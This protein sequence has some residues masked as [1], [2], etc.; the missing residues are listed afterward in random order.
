MLQCTQQ[1]ERER[2]MDAA[3][4]STERERK[5]GGD[6]TVCLQHNLW[7]HAPHAVTEP[8]EHYSP[9]DN[10]LLETDRENRLK[11]SFEEFCMLNSLM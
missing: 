9:W 3:M 4:Y 1:R 7:T 5:G 2:E 10:L 8:T 11:I 6:E